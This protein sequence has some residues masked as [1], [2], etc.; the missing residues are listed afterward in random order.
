MI[1]VVQEVPKGSF[2]ETERCCFCRAKT[3]FWFREKDVACC[4][5]C[6]QRA[7]AEDVPDKLSWCRRERIATG[8]SLIMC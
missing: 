6:A 4:E 2:N 1:T 3:H 8:G 5:K 7:N